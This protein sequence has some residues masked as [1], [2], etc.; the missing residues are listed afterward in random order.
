MKLWKRMASGLLALTLVLGLAACGG[1]TGTAKNPTP[2]GATNIA[3]PGGTAD[4]NAS[5]EGEIVVN[6]SDNVTL[7]NLEVYAN[8]NSCEFLYADL[9]FDPLY[10]GDRQGSN[11]PCICT[12]YELNEDGT[13][14]TLHIKE[15]VKFHDG[16]ELNAKDVVATFE[17]IL[18][19]KD[20][21]GLAS[22]VWGNLEGVELIDDNTCK[23]TLS[24]YFA[25]FENSLTYT[26]ILSDEDIEKYGD[27]FQSAERIINGSGPWKFVEWQDGQYARYTPNKDYWD[28]SAVSNID[29][30]SVWFV[31]QENA[32]VS[33]ITSGD[34]D[35]AQSLRSDMVPMVENLDGVNIIEYTSDVMYYM[36]FDCA[37]DSIFSDPNARK[38]AAYALDVDT[39]LDLVGGGDKMNCMF[40]PS[41]LGYDES[42]EGYSYDP[43]LA[44]EYL[45]KTDYDGHQLTLYTRN[46]LVAI[47]DVM[48]VFVQNL[49]DVGF[50]VTTKIC[51]SAE[52]V[53]IR[54]HPSAYDIFFINLGAFDADPY[55]LYI[56]PRI[57][58]DCHNSY[59]KNEAL[60]DLITK[61]YT[62]VDAAEREDLLKQVAKIV[63]DE[64]GP[65]LGM[66]ATKSYCVMRDG[67]EGVL[68]TKGAGPYFRY[69]K[70]DEAVWN[71]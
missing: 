15:G 36:Q 66:Y 12:G 16:T 29:T 53:T 60:N 41:L 31:N 24:S 30:L 40:L 1:N 38:A 27:D 37:E 63:Y 51:D 70:V 6:V 32:K 9:V 65:V 42:I 10:Y 44:K 55:T 62:T 19:N 13:E 54:Q 25:T 35:Y 39:A 3:A 46:D 23:I 71:K 48:A 22:A 45:A 43:E 52:F 20:T 34:L 17:F 64:C 28:Q 61:S 5:T 57:V 33:G 8:N 18:R 56:V 21:L 7:I 67:L 49:T 58:N 14:A 59:Y 2:G 68:V 47:D 26:W 50:N 4:P 11:T 69:A